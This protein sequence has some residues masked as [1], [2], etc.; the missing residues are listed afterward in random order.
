MQC[1]ECG[2][3]MKVFLTT[4]DNIPVAWNCKDCRETYC[5]NPTVI[6]KKKPAKRVYNDIQYRVGR[7]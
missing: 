4:D 6:R 1:P 7:V 2:N 3:H 5:G